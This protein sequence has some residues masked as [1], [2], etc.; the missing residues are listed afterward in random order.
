MKNRFTLYALALERFA[1]FAEKT[2]LQV[3]NGYTLQDKNFYLN[4]DLKGKGGAIQLVDAN[5]KKIDGITNFD[6]NRLNGGRHIII[7]GIR[8]Q[9]ENTATTLGAATWDGT[10]TPAVKN[11][12]LKISQGK[13]I[14]FVPVSDLLV[15]DTATSNS[16]DFRE[17][18]HLPIIA[19]DVDY[20]IEWQFPDGVSVLGDAGDPPCFGRLEFH[21]HEVFV[22]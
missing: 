3:K 19:P 5:T 18:S 22:K 1:N 9:A 10:A 15:K 12:V 8:Y 16:D 11:S 21:T 7:D 13:E 17:I 14:L 20:K 6:G 4:V 2:N